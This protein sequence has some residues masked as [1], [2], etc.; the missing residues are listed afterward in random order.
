LTAFA[1]A[2][3]IASILLKIVAT[4]LGVTLVLYGSMGLL[5]FTLAGTHQDVWIRLA[6]LL[7]V[8]MGFVY[9]IPSGRVIFFFR[10]TAIY[11]C[12]CGVPYLVTIVC[13]GFTVADSGWHSFVEQGGVVTS[14]GIF[15][16]AG[17]APISYYLWGREK[18]VKTIQ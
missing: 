8:V 18:Q 10:K 15:M 5:G 1:K 17:I 6:A 4:I 12:V 16:A 14:I 3:H 2:T 7:M 11:Y 9:T 13:G